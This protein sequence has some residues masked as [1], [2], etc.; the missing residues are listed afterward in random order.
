MRFVDGLKNS[1]RLLWAGLVLGFV[2]VGSLHG[3]SA[4]AQTPP[5]GTEVKAVI[6]RPSS[7]VSLS[8]PP[9]DSLS[10]RA[11]V[12]VRGTVTQ[13]TQ[14]ELYV[15]DQFDRVVPLSSDEKS[16]EAELTMS[17]GTHTIRAVAIDFCQLK[18]GEGEVIV[19][20]VPP[21]SGS[22]GADVPTELPGATIPSGQQGVTGYAALL[23]VVLREPT[24]MALRW[25][26]ISTADSAQA[27]PQL[28]F[29]RALVIAVAAYLGVF[30]VSVG[31]AHRLRGLFVK[32]VPVRPPSDLEIQRAI[33]WSALA[34]LLAALFF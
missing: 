3:F 14:V 9:S 13:A 1:R 33:R 27:A 29:V 22:V 30:G 31:I 26:N 28:S 7:T 18:N 21:G 19:T 10:E 24:E 16:F 25:L 20:Y 6:C 17:P 23:P 32:L 34:A 5:A 8:S 15:D 12:L 11:G 2:G 4:Y